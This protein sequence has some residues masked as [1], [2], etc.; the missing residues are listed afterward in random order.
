MVYRVTLFRVDRTMVEV[1]VNGLNQITKPLDRVNLKAAPEMF[2]VREVEITRPVGGVDQLVG[3][4][5]AK[6]KSMPR[7]YSRI[8]PTN[9]PHHSYY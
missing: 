2:V 6:R 9:L 4:N 3:I 5:L 7:T 8:Q 1:I